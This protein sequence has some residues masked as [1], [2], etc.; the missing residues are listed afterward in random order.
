MADISIIS[1]SGKVVYLQNSI[2]LSSATIDL[3][4]LPEGLYFVQ[5]SSDASIMTQKLALE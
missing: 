5:I 4:E 1:T 2:N 3:S